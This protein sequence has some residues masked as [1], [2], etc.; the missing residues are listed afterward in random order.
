MA[1]FAR[2]LISKI[3]KEGDIRPAMQAGVRVTWFDED[4]DHRPVFKWMLEYFGRYGTTPTEDAF[5]AEFPSYKLPTPDEPYLFYLDHFRDQRSRAILFDAIADGDDAL[6]AGETQEAQ[7]HL[8]NGLQQ[9]GREISTTT[10]ENAVRRPKA[11]YESYLERARTYGT[12]RGIPCGFAS[13]DKVTGGWQAEQFVLLGGS[14]K[15]A[16]SFVLMRWA[17]A[18]QESGKKVLFLTF[19][20]SRDE[21]LA[22]YDAIAAGIS[23]KRLFDGNLSLDEKRK[24]RKAMKAQRDLVPFVVSADI[25]ATTTI[26]GLSAKVEQHQPDIVFVDGCYLMENEIGAEP[27]STQA[28]TSISRGLKRLAQQS[29]R[30]IVA[31]TQALLSKMK[32]NKVDLYSFGWCVDEKT[33]ALTQDGWKTYHTLEAGDMIWTLNHETGE[34]EWQPVES[35]QIFAPERRSMVHMQGGSG[36]GHSSL[37]T[38]NHHWPVEHRTNFSEGGVVRRGIGRRWK[39]TETLNNGDQLILSAPNAD[40]PITQKYSDAF[41]ELVAWLWTEG[42]IMSKYGNIMI[43]QSTKHSANLARIRSALLREYGYE[44]WRE[45]VRIDRPTSAFF[46]LGAEIGREL[47]AVVSRPHKVVSWQFLREL[48]QSQL[49]LFIHVS[50]LGDR[51]S[52]HSLGQ[53][54]KARAEAFQFACILSGRATSMMRSRHKGYSRKLKWTVF[55]K[56]RERCAPV[57]S[58][59]LKQAFKI[60]RVKYNGVI[61][62]PVTPNQ[63]WFARRRGSTYFTGNTSA[64]AQDADVLL[65]IERDENGA[66]ATVKVIAGRSVPSCKIVVST[67]FAESVFE[68]M[69]VETDD[70]D[71]Q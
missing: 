42:T 61:W 12:L 47:L 19:E 8:A 45:D 11:R 70:F 13:L 2:S 62:C 54:N 46:Y 6:K 41:V 50:M 35:V 38:P 67:N 17:R 51:N 14:P 32:N 55:I 23:A 20:M 52:T 65:G 36:A 71:D 33:E 30:P 58:A 24:L 1:D 64:W 66:M 29:K 34:A 40:L 4:S 68:E 28:F 16:K 10:D 18:A 56:L 44:G 25:S 43:D 22:R 5:R 3:I 69:D 15:Q 60:R 9:I 49:E 48:T 37:T 57:R 31:T 63:T 21:Q 59:A 27:L 39:T 26:S 7:R 53:A